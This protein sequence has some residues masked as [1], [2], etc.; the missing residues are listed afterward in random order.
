MFGKIFSC[1]G[2]LLL[3]GAVLLATPG[4]GWARAGHV[5]GGHFGGAHFGGA[6]I[7]TGHIGGYRGGLYHG[8]YRSGYGGN[9]SYLGNNHY[10]RPYYGYYPYNGYYPNYGYGYYPYD[11]YP[12]LASGVA[13]DLGYDGDYA[14]VGPAYPNDTNSD[15][16]NVTD[17]QSYYPPATGANQL[18]GGAHVTVN[19][20]TDARI[21]FDGTLTTT[22]GSV[23]RFDTP[24][25]ESDAQYAYDVK[26]SWNDNGRE[27]T[28]S[29]TV[30]VTA[31]ANVNVRFPIPPK[32]AGQALAGS[33]G[34]SDRK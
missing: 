19:V 30:K 17:H 31:G 18:T 9:R 21:W 13:T 14:G 2:M 10:Y 1:G 6:H 16:P 12:Y 8:G 33:R 25:L 27:V 29:Q 22:T 20:P 5:G 26:A 3:A 34:Q 11:T 23:R 32:R 4:S 15:S 28:Q 24:P 7:S